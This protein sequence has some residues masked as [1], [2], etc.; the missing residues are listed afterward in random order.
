MLCILILRQSSDRVLKKQFSGN[1]RFSDWYAVEEKIMQEDELMSFFVQDRNISLKENP[2]RPQS[3]TYIRHIGISTSKG[4][5]FATARDG[6]P[7]WIEKNGRQR[8]NY[9]YGRV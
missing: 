6:E 9:S 3:S 2:I 8:E 4:R 5:E 1:Q 7:V